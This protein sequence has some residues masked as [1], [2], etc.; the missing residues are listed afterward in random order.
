MI[1]VE[2]KFKITPGTRE[3]LES[4]LAAL[5]AARLLG[6]TKN[7]D[8]YFDSPD[9]DCL[10]QAV[11]IRIRNNANLEIKYHECADLM[12]THSTERVFPLGATA[13]QLIELNALCARYIMGWHAA[14]DVRE[15]LRVNGLQALA[16]IE[17]RRAQY[18]SGNMLLCIDQVYDLGDF[19]EIETQCAEETQADQALAEIKRFITALDFPYLEPVRVG[20]VELWLRSHLPEV[21]CLGKYLVEAAADN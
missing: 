20:Y 19:F 8:I 11:F 6:Y 12:H 21:Y 7:M 3:Q 17:K 15:A 16:S 5:P 9:F 2:L 13:E 1:E 18:A 10:R 4:G 14:G